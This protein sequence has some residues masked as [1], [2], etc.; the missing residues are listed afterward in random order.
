MHS[1]YRPLMNNAWML[2][3]DDAT[4]H[5]EPTVRESSDGGQLAGPAGPSAIMSAR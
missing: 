2:D 1:S 3:D 5:A 4:T